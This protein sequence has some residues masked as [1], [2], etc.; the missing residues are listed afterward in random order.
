MGARL[1]AI[2][3][4]QCVEFVTGEIKRGRGGWILTM[5]LDHL[6]R[7]VQSPGSYR[8]YET[9]NIVTADGMP[10]LWAS[11]AQGTP[12]PERV[13]GSDLILSLSAA[14][15]RCGLGIFLVG[16]SPGAAERTAAVLRSRHPDLR[17]VGVNTDYFE[18]AGESPEMDRLAGQIVAS[19]PDL[20]F[21]GISSPKAERIVER[22]TE[23]MDGRLPSAWWIGVGISFSFVAGLIPR[24]PRWMRRA[25]LEWAH[26]LMYE[27]RRLAKRYL[28]LGLPFGCLLM[29][30]AASRRIGRA[31]RG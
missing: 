30:H 13:S 2:T 14:A 3:E 1:H 5:N 24:A 12:L 29:A 16:G 19:Q 26:R 22:L 7:Y 31:L 10:L 23:Q 25:G 18:T 15:A 21:L 6:R 4:P 8:L 20:V 17:I 27:P 11:R 9:A 28:L